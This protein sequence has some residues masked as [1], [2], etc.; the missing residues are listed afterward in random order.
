MGFVHS[1]AHT[2]WFTVDSGSWSMDRWLVFGGPS[3]PFFPLAWSMCT[4]CRRVRPA[5][6][7]SASFPGVLPPVMCS[8]ASS[9]GGAGVQLRWGKASP[10]L[11]VYGGGVKVAARASW[12]FGH[13][14]RRP[15]RGG[16]RRR[17][18]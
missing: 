8:P 2:V 12:G 5:R 18:T 15:D 9:Y 11:S 13:G 7:S 14:G 4:G 16:A 1:S 17:G 10:G 6:E 3:P